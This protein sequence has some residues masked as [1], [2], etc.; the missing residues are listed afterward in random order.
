M[1]SHPWG[2]KGQWTQREP[3]EL[4]VYD[5]THA[6]PYL[7]AEQARLPMR[8]PSRLLAPEEFDARLSEGDRR[9]GAFLYRPSCPECVACEAIRLPVREFRF[10]RS[11]RRSL[12]KG[13]RSLRLEVGPPRVDDERVALYEL[14]KRGRGLSTDESQPLGHDGYRGFLVERCVDSIELR[15]L[16]DGRLV[17]VSVADR[18]L[19]SMSAV[20]CFWDPSFA[21]LGVGTYAILEQVELCRR[22][23]LEYLYLGLY[24]AENPHMNYKARFRPHERLIDGSWRRFDPS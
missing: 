6:C 17:A 20:Y 7:S 14:H 22:L 5:E 18:G 12:A 19:T 10:T 13:R 11:L 3:P 15:F 2:V 23:G 1:S 16:L 9:H 8:L 21:R 4:I 24:I